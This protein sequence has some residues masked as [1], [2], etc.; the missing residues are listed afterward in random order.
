MRTTTSKV[1]VLLYR[2]RNRQYLDG[3]KTVSASSRARGFTGTDLTHWFTGPASM[4]VTKSVRDPAGTMSLV[5]PERQSVEGGWLYDA[6]EPGDLI[7]VRFSRKPV[8]GLPPVYMRAVVTH[9]E[10]ELSVAGGAPRHMVSIRAADFGHVL[11]ILRAYYKIDLKYAR[12]LL[13]TFRMFTEYVA[14]TPTAMSATDFLS[15]LSKKTL[16]PV[17]ATMA[18]VI[19]N[20]PSGFTVDCSITDCINPKVFS[21][22]QNG[23]I[24]TL[25]R[26]TLDVGPFN[27][28]FIESVGA[29]ER[30]VARPA[31]WRTPAGLF[32]LPGAKAP[33]ST[34]LDFYADVESI[35][36]G[37]S[38]DGVATYFLVQSPSLDLGNPFSTARHNGCS[39][40]A[41]DPNA[42]PDVFGIR[43]LDVQ[44]ATHPPTGPLKAAVTAAAAD[45]ESIR[46]TQW[47]QSKRDALMAA[48]RD[49][50]VFESGTIVCADPSIRAGSEVV[51]SGAVGMGMRYYVPQV[52]TRYDESGLTTT[53]SV[54]RG[55]GWIDGQ[56][57]A[58]GP[59]S[60][61]HLSRNIK[62]R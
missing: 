41:G 35:R 32:A 53:L 36:V 40:E 20:F 34:V 43:P 54:E 16:D 37:R 46:F 30:I 22:S 31:P 14:E 60:L 61:L 44:M 45:S 24:G 29:P 3:L 17:L 25:I 39:T 42:D 18:G 57:S 48:N 19:G 11:E 55:T 28:F 8:A 52:S 6:V 50:L 7:E 33:A 4:T 62:G 38:D 56:K 10:R 13:D 59:A 12:N 23:S 27:E 47:L 1:A 49:A 26:N 21:D 9:V 5:L 15:M 58:T 51:L 2:R